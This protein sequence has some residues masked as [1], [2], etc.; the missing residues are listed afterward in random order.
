MSGLLL[1]L[2]AT[3]VVL[4]FLVVAVLTTP[5]KLDLMVR[6]SPRW[7]IRI[8]VRLLG[9]LTPQIPIHDSARARRKV[10]KP[11][12]RKKTAVIVSDRTLAKTPDIIMA[13]PRLLAGVLRPIRLRRLRVDADIGLADPADT[14]HIFGLIAALSFSWSRTSPVSITVRP[15]FTGPRV[16]GKLDAELSF[17]PVAFIP[18]GVR[19]ARRVFGSSR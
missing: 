15:D 10:K 14:G 8:A 9:G 6:T 3:L 19:F 13:M 5:A 4:L 2:F 18:P 12:G 17:I 7:R 16:F 1:W 11:A